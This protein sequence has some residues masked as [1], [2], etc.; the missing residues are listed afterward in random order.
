[1]SNSR[2][3]DG[4]VAIAG[5]HPALRRIMAAIS[6]CPP[7]SYD[8]AI[9]RSCFL[10]SDVMLMIWLSLWLVGLVNVALCPEHLDATFH[11]RQDLAGHDDGLDFID[12]CDVGCRAPIVSGRGSFVLDAILDLFAKPADL[13]T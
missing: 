1:M 3:S 2:Q 13:T 4:W 11:F 7:R 8:S 10:W 9:S 6:G 12:P 5:V